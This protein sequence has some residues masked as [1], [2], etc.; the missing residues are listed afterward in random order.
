MTVLVE[1]KQHVA[2]I[3]DI[4]SSDPSYPLALYTVQL[5][6]WCKHHDLDDRVQYFGSQLAHLMEGTRHPVVT[7]V[8][9]LY[10]ITANPAVTLPPD[11]KQDIARMVG[12]AMV[13]VMLADTSQKATTLSM[14]MND[15]HHEVFE[16]IDPEDPLVSEFE[17]TATM[18]REAFLARLAGASPTDIPAEVLDQIVA[19]IS[20][21]IDSGQTIDRINVI[22]LRGIDEPDEDS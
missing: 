14:E 11:L 1:A 13:F 19:V 9:P 20:D 3:E 8:Y 5:L 21:L 22:D 10:K 17:A 6:R 2:A 7:H 16:S 18:M 12:L 15:L 4:V